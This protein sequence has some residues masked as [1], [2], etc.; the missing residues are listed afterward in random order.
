MPKNFASVLPNS[1]K[2]DWQSVT[3][4]LPRLCSSMASWTLHEVQDPQAP[5][6]VITASQRLEYS[7]MM[8]A[9]APCM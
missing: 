5:R 6:P 1:I 9:G 4:G 8:S 3:V 7:F 2:M